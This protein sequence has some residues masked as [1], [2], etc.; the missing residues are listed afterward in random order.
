MLKMVRVIAGMD[1]QYERHLDGLK[2][3]FN[4]AFS[5]NAPYIG[6]IEA[7]A[8]GEHPPGSECIIL[9]ATGVREEVLGF[10]VTFYFSDL[11][12]AY[13]DYI[14]S[15]P[16]RSSR[17]IGA[18]LYEAMR[19]DVKKR[20]ARRLFFD[21]LP[22]EP[23]PNLV[24]PTLLPNNKK[25][26][27]FY[28]RL[29]ARPILGT[30]YEHLVTPA[31][32][33]DPNYLMHDGL[34]QTTPLSRAKLKAV[35]A[36]IMLAKC[37]LAPDQEPLKTLLASVKDDPVQIRAPRYPAPSPGPLP[38]LRHSIDLI[39]TG[40]AN[41]IS[42][43]PFKGYYERPARVAAIAK[44]LD[45]LPIIR[46]EIQDFGLKPILEI[47]DKRMVNFLKESQT[48]VP[49]GQI[50][51]PEIFPI[52]Y[53]DR[54]PQNW[55]MRA[56]YFCI[57]TSTPITSNVFAAATRSANAA[58]TAAKLV[59]SGKSEMA[60][61]AGRP[62]GHHAERKVF[63]GFCYFNNAALA[64]NALSRKGRV[65]V[66]DVDHHHGNGTQDIF[67]S[68]RDV[69]T[70]SIHG[71]PEFS[72]PFYAGFED[73][74]GE[75]DGAG[76]NVNFPLH[77]G[78]DDAAYLTAL[79]KALKVI[80]KFAPDY[81]VVSLGVDIMRGDPTGAFYVSAEGMRNIGRAIGSLR[82]PSVIIQ[83]GGYHLQNLRRGVRGFLVGYGVGMT[84]AP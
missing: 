51:Y 76:F 8:R 72:Y 65:A 55:P 26:M 69:L 71:H 13:L 27:A 2:A 77:P 61:V 18:A 12:A 31:N 20:G 17:G 15:D 48:K 83:E 64:A 36:R 30:Q 47:H 49:A 41:D 82:L 19:N 39:E 3:V 70:V 22:D 54:L 59:G 9:A 35:I 11:K 10:T 58:L 81:L 84:P 25:R 24:D 57:D 75:G 67:Y 79:D 80:R 38:K 60:Y 32:L 21:S 43:S 1:A 73:E 6:K 52:R 34:G 14:A 7:F 45:D 37:S 53:P 50:V 5:F 66:L 29:G 78:V 42:H 46:H 62:P 68:R 63:G 16:D 56:G 28:E 33:G 4:K 40:T 74:K 44:A 23:G